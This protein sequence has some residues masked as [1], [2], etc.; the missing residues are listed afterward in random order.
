MTRVSWN[1]FVYRLANNE[2]SC[3]EAKPCNLCVEEGRTCYRGATPA[4]PS[5]S[6]Q[7][8][9]RACTEYYDSPP[10]SQE[11]RDSSPLLSVPGSSLGSS[12][13]RG[14]TTPQAEAA[15][16]S[17]S[18]NTQNSGLGDDRIPPRVF[19]RS[20]NPSVSPQ[21]A[22]EAALGKWVAESPLESPPSEKWPCAEIWQASVC[23]VNHSRWL[24]WERRLPNLSSPSFKWFE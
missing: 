17:E 3:N 20:A 18:P 16:R 6:N 4:L 15:R 19:V 1:D 14:S 23:T 22:E 21:R 9:S 5:P 2:K 11:S 7:G 10:E 12:T 24:N 8:S 13:P